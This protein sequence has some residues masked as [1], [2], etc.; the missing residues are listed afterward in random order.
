M[1]TGTNVDQV[2]SGLERNDH[3]E[4]TTDNT[5]RLAQDE[6][7]RPPRVNEPT[8]LDTP[9]ADH[10]GIRWRGDFE[11]NRPL[12]WVVSAPR[13]ASA[14]DQEQ[15]QQTT[16]S[17]GPSRVHQHPSMRLASAREPSCAI[18]GLGIT[19]FGRGRTDRA[20][21]GFRV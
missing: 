17:R 21:L 6:H 1:S 10:R 15:K 16:G 3:A 19:Q 5:S 13:S 14:R 4:L 8:N 11:P 7:P 20:H 9:V 12:G 18:G 2:R